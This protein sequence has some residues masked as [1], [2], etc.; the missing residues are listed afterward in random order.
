MGDKKVFMLRL[1]PAVYEALEKWAADEF[2]SVNG[3]I[4]WILDMKL[5]EH[6]RTPKKN[7]SNDFQKK[8]A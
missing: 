5:K 4:E 8:Q 6:K 1:A 2:R 3:Q 7:L